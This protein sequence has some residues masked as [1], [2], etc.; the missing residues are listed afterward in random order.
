MALPKHCPVRRLL[1]P[2]YHHGDLRNAL[3]TEGLALLEQWGQASFSLRDLARRVGVS[4]AALYTHFADKDAL[5]AAIATAGFTHLAAAIQAA[6]RADEG[7]AEQFLRMGWAYVSFGISHPALYKLMFA[8]EELAAKHG[9]FPELQEAGAAAFGLLTD[10]LAQMQRSGSLRAGDPQADGL[11][12]WAHVHGLT[13][14][15]ISGCIECTA[16]PAPRPAD[17]VQASLMTLLTG[18]RPERMIAEAT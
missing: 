17:V 6:L 1:K 3:I 4:A 14:L 5:L 10:K 8:S 9:D 15:I 2:A 13:S 7:E 12:V 11:A 18:L 16:D